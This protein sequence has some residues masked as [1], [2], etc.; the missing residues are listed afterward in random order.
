MRSTTN[1]VYAI[2]GQ[3]LELRFMLGRPTSATFEVFRD[4]ADD[5]ATAEFTGTATLTSPTTTLTAASGAGQTDPQKLNLTSTSI[6][7]G[8]RYLLSE[9]SVREWVDPIQI[10]SG[11]IRARYPLQNAY[12]T[13]ATLASTTLTATVDATWIAMLTSIGNP[14]DPNPD[15]RVKWSVVYSGATYVV[16][17]YFDVVRSVVAHQVDISDINDRAPGLM[18]SLPVEY[19]AEQGRPLIDAAWRAVHAKLASLGIDVDSFRDDS[20]VDELVVMKACQILAIGGWRPAGYQTIS[21]YV[22]V[23]TDA[24]DRFI[25][26]HVQVQLKHRIDIGQGGGADIARA[27]PYWAK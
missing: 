14:K 13:A 19:E 21:E 18:D 15:Y 5:T 16:Y 24:F 8:R 12:T 3:T 6:V 10:A 9:A 26:Q 27:Q 11:Y 23:T 7:T 20:F 4:Y 22:A 1:I 2:S 17:S 25:E